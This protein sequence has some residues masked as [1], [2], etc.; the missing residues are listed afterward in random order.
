MTR[1]PAL[2]VLDFYLNSCNTKNRN[3]YEQR[4]RQQSSKYGFC[5]EG[6]M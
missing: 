2:F 6:I 5:I 1:V 4:N 3:G